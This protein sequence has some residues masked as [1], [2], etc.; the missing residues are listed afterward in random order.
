[1]GWEKWKWLKSKKER[2]LGINEFE[3]GLDVQEG[4]EVVPEVDV[5]MTLQ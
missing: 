3:K 2:H 4:L 5:E 1:M